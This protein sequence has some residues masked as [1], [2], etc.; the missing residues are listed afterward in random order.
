MLS[1]ER[2]IIKWDGKSSSD[3]NVIYNRYSNNDSFV[4]EI[5]KLIQQETLQKGTTWL[6]KRYLENGR[7]IAPNEI[8]TIF[9]LLPKLEHWESKLH[10]LQCIRFM[11]IA[12]TEKKGV[13]KFLR[14]CLTDSNK[15]VRAWAYHGFYEIS[16]QYPEYKNETKQL[17]EIAMRDEASS[18]K[19]RIRNVIKKGF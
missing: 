4:S 9:N 11:Q 12:K 3:I 19:A 8:S 14:K 18:V 2:E 15:F 1:I 7:A 6:L 5:I 10:I 13:E 16:I 17:F